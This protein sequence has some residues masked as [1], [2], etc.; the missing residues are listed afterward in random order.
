MSPLS[1]TLGGPKFLGAIPLFFCY[2]QVNLRYLR[3]TL[4]L[5]PTV[6]LSALKSDIISVEKHVVLV[7]ALR[8]DLVSKTAS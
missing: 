1:I 6:I 2:R 3:P 8:N 5:H 4:P 7:V